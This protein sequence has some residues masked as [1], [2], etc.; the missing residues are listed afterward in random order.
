MK[1]Y[2]RILVAATALI[3]LCSCDLYEMIWGPWTLDA[4]TTCLIEGVRFSSSP[5]EISRP[6]WPITSLKTTENSFNISY[7]RNLKSADSSATLVIDLKIDE[8]FEI[9]KKYECT[10]SITV[11]ET[12]YVMTEGWIKFRD[13]N[14]NKDSTTES[15]I[16]AVFEF[17]AQSESGD[18]VQVTEGTFEELC[19]NHYY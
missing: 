4:P 18:V 6:M 17:S 11:K 1:S 5:E 2:I 14:G 7:S 13:Y 19:I 9:G 8:V 16:S 10:G 12:E 3:M 15:Y